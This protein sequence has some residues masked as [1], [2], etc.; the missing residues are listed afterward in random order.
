MK[1]LLVNDYAI[2]FGGA[3]LQI[4]ALRD[5][6]RQRG[7]DARLFASCA[8]PGGGHSFADYECF[9]TTSRFR[10]LL[11][12][13]NLSAF[14][15]LRRV[16]AGFQPDVVHVRVFLTQ[17]SPLILPLLRN[18]PS[19]EQ[20]V[21]YKPI[22]PLGTKMLPDG[23]I[24]QVSAGT[25][26]YRN[27]CLPLRD[28]L[29]LMLQMHL[30]RRWR[31]AFNLVVTNSEAVKLRLVAEGIQLEDV[32]WNGVQSCPPRPPL[33]SPPTVAFAGRLVR[34]KGVDVLLQAFAMVVAQVAEARLLVAGSGPEGEHL[35]RLIA[36]L[37]LSDSVA[38]L[39]HLSRQ[40]LEHRFAQ[41]WVQAIPSRW[42]E[43]FANVALEALMRGTAV[44]AS[45]S[46]G[47]TEIVQ[48]GR[49][50]FLVPS[51]DAGTLAEALLKLLRDREL[52][53]QIG[54]AGREVA[55]AHFS[56]RTCVDR[57]VEL[58]HRLCHSGASTR[59]VSRKPER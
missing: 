28:W 41:A 36:D 2:P 21:S 45:A 9:G 14:W 20:T 57:F 38:T 24:C 49:T 44:V 48:D 25:V 10:T 22:C 47:L 52:A 13:A 26:C 31:Y 40:E 46:G 35:K 34:E 33:S 59:A 29:P 7:H 39:G 54:K 32:I 23:T 8:K 16:L 12:T 42:E 19:L 17:L 5:S 53:E 6:L 43:P 1:I 4:L 18:V 56:E 55:L 15:Q 11:Q 27:H 3:E 37:G 51:G 30:Y 58:Y 50:G